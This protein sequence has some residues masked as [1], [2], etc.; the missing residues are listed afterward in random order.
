MSAEGRC[1][2]RFDGAVL[3]LLGSDWGCRTRAR[4][5]RVSTSKTSLCLLLRGLARGGQS[6]GL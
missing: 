3:R 4:A 1:L 2:A 5:G 6:T